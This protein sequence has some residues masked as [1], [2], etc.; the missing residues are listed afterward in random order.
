M[1]R[2]RS[3]PGWQ[4]AVACVSA[5]ALTAGLIVGTGV[6]QSSAP[7]ASATGCTG[8]LSGSGTSGDPYIVTTRADL[9]SLRACTSTTN[10]YF[11]QTK[12]IDMAS[13]GNWTPISSF[14]GT[15][16]G[17]GCSITNMTVAGVDGGLFGALRGGSVVK[18]L[19]L[20]SV[21]VTSPGSTG[22]LAAGTASN[23]GGVGVTL[24]GVVVSGSVSGSNSYVGGVMGDP[25]HAN[26]T[27]N[28][29]SFTGSVA[30][31]KDY[32]GGLF[33]SPL[34]AGTVVTESYA[35]G[36]VSGTREVGGLFGY[37]KGSVSNS[38]AQVAT[39]ATATSS[40]NT[41]KGEY[42]AAS[43]IAHANGATITNSYATG[44]ATGGGH[45]GVGSGDLS[46]RQP[47]H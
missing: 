18:N 27:A 7:P 38:Y 29:V 4:V 17:Q 23:V 9:E 42:A 31:T 13:G 43:L 34:G 14:S 26:L 33:G 1:S 6:W 46:P 15:Y 35:S 24:D 25:Y 37:F 19:K 44:V 11:K 21:S 39:T 36:T 5:A 2:S 20:T 16:D 40:Q 28:H 10:V 47:R 3:M 45:V 8:S 41:G 12:S 32:V 30:G 22:A